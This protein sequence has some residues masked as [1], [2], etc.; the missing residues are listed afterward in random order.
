MRALG[1]SFSVHKLSLPNVIPLF[2]P[3][4]GEEEFVASL[5]IWFEHLNKKGMTHE[6]YVNIRNDN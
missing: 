6:M 5:A 3:D 4:F 2:V 1:I